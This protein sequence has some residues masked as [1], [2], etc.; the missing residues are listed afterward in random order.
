MTVKTRRTV[1]SKAPTRTATNASK[2]AARSPKKSA[3]RRGAPKTT[4]ADTIFILLR[5]AEGVTLA[6]L[7]KAVG[8][9]PNSVRGFLHGPVMKRAGLRLRSQRVGADE[10][11][12]FL[13][14]K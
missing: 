5:R 8:W 14:A 6:A 11:R 7:A 3:K 13:G 4:K 1:A 2:V 9:K 12:Y 10:R